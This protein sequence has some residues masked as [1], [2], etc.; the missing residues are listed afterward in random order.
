MLFL[1][2]PIKKIKMKKEKIKKKIAP[3]ENPE[4]KEIS[5]RLKEGML[6]FITPGE[7]SYTEEDVEKC[8]SLIS[9]YIQ[10]IGNADSEDSGM[11]IVEKTVLSLNELNENCEYELIETDQSEDI[12]KIM[13]LVGSLNGLNSIEDDITEEWRE[14]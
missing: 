13:I 14:W 8:M 7:T 12:V 1:E 9:N 11:K 4:I 10:E 2:A 5:K 6:D 3:R